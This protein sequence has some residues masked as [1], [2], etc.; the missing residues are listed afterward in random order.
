MDDH[1]PA[2]NQLTKPV[3]RAITKELSRVL[4]PV[5]AIRS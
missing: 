5:R 4:A 1:P 2:R 3:G